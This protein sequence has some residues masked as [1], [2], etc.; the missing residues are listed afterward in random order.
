MPTLENFAY[1]DTPTREAL[2]GLLADVLEHP[3]GAEFAVSEYEL[4]ARHDLRPLVLKTVLTYLEL[5][6][7]LRQG[8][9]FY[10]GYRLRPLGDASLEEVFGRFD[11]AR[12][13]F[14]RRLIATGKTGRTW[15]TLAPDDAA[16]ELGEERSRIVAALEY[17]DQQGLVELQPAELRQRY[18]LLARPDSERRARRAP[19]RALRAPGARG[20]RPDR[21]RPR[22]RHPRRLPG[23]RPRR[24][25]RRDARP[26]RAGTAATA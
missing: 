17:L 13:G 19:A 7:V 9:P 3:V 2:A 24:L 22:A 10:A 21:E 20:D 15:T 1:G 5:D 26:S 18:T 6:G 4:S 25:L 14:L 23:V 11:E 12:A 16:A 8:T